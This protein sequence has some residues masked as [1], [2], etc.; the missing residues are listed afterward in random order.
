MDVKDDRP[1]STLEPARPHSEA[2]QTEKQV[3]PDTEKQFKYD[4]D[5]LE[6]VSEHDDPEKEIRNLDEEALDQHDPSKTRFCRKRL[7]WLVLGA[8]ILIAAILGGVLGGIL[9]SRHSSS[10]STSA[11]GRS[12]L[13]PRRDVA[14]VSFTQNS[15]NHTRAYFQDNGGQLMEA[16][17][18]ADQ[19]TWKTRGLGLSGKNRSTIA[20][21]VSRPGLPLGSKTPLQREAAI[22]TQKFRRS[23]CSILIRTT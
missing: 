13:P 8:I 16:A 6:S 23:A 10:E 14:A 17:Y 15:V 20:A 19:T 22:P 9:G 7:L 12:R 2:S 21:A 11:D 18:Q 5:G 3:V 1:Y 4:G